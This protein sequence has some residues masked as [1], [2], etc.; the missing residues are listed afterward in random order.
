VVLPTGVKEL[1]EQGSQE[2]SPHTDTQPEIQIVDALPEQADRVLEFLGPFIDRQQLLPRT[3]EEIKKLV[4]N[5]FIAKLHDQ[6]VGFAAI[7]IYSR[8]LAEIQCWA[9]SET[10]QKRGIGSRLIQLCVQRA[11]D[12]GVLELMVI[13]ASDYLL[14][15]C[16]FDYSLPNQK[17]ALFIQPQQTIE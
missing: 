8:K 3:I 12:R 9:V 16:G 4:E 14:Q 1:N 6:I 17:R 15:R 13:T 2:I 10:V 5:G 7:E 11:K